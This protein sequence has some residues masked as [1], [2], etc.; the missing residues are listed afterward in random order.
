LGGNLVQTVRIESGSRR[1]IQAGA[2]LWRPGP[3]CGQRQQAQLPDLAASPF[4]T[5]PTLASIGFR[6]GHP[7]GSAAPLTWAAGTYARL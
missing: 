4:G 7:A 3:G 2:V 5:D 1:R 6:N